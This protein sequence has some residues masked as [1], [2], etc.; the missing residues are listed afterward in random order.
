MAVLAS[1]A[2]AESATYGAQEPEQERI[3]PSPPEQS[4]SCRASGSSLRRSRSVV[5]GRL[6][7][8]LRG[9][10]FGDRQRWEQPGG[11][12]WWSSYHDRGLRRLL[13]ALNSAVLL[14]FCARAANVMAPDVGVRIG[15]LCYD[16]HD[17]L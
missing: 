8:L 17:G 13:T 5:R 15:V 12:Y 14:E 9:P 2:N 10:A 6:R 16:V 3:P 4:T 1:V 11:Q 7:R